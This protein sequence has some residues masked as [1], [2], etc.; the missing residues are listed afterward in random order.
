MSNYELAQLNVGKLIAPANSPIVAEFFDNLDR[1]NALAESSP[2][3]LWRLQDEDGNAT[4]LRPFGE[5]VL[6]NMSVW[7]DV[8]SL[9]QFVYKS[10]HAKIM[11]KRANWFER[12]TQVHMVLWWIPAKTRPSMTDAGLRL[13]SLLAKGDTAYAFSFKHVFP[14]PSA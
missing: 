13:E 1:V 6:V 14:M 8:E 11:Y 5:D 12:S 3:F 2:G 10:A 9:Q 4:S 7:K